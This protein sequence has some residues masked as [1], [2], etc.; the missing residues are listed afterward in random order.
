MRAIIS[1]ITLMVM[2]GYTTV[3]AAQSVGLDRFDT[4]SA[5][6]DFAEAIVQARAEIQVLMDAGAPGVSIAC[7]LY[8]SDAADE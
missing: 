5:A 8:T 7:L 3:A 6:S 1:R 2:F 4:V